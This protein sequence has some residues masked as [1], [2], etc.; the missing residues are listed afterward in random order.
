LSLKEISGSS[1][2]E[3]LLPIGCGSPEKL[4]GF[5]RALGFQPTTE[6]RG[7]ASV[8]I[9]CKLTILPVPTQELDNYVFA[10]VTLNGDADGLDDILRAGENAEIMEHHHFY[11]VSFQD[12][13]GRCWQA[14]IRKPQENH[15][16]LRT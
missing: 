15:V 5:L 4:L 6:S 8:S 3:V 2:A 16:E 1:K 11:E 12:G 10:C 7:Q 9:V 13:S 14:I